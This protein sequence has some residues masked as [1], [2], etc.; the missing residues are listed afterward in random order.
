MF[1]PSASVSI[2]GHWER[3]LKRES[4]GSGSGLT[5]STIGLSGRG[6]FAAPWF[7][8]H[9]AERRGEQALPLRGDRVTMGGKHRAQRLQVELRRRLCDPEEGEIFD[10]DYEDYH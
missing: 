5:R 1:G 2:T 10:L 7:R 4:T 8:I 9:H 6:R 3:T